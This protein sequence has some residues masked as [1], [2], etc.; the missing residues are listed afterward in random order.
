MPWQWTGEVVSVQLQATHHCQKGVHIDIVETTLHCEQLLSHSSITYDDDIDQ[1]S[2][3]FQ[4]SRS[5]TK[6]PQKQAQLPEIP[7][8]QEQRLDVY[9]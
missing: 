4:I 1:I 7:R 2:H 9:G 3:W 5:W 8:G 6:K